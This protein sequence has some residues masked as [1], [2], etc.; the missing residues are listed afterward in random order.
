[1][2]SNCSKEF[3]IVYGSK[4]KR[5]ALLLSNLLS[6]AKINATYSDEVKYNAQE[7]SFSNQNKVVFV[8]DSKIAKDHA[9]G[10]IWRFN[11]FGIKYGW[12]GNSALICVEHTHMSRT[13]FQEFCNFVDEVKVKIDKAIE[14]A[15]QHLAP[16]IAGSENSSSAVLSGIIAGATA[17]G[18]VAASA[19]GATAIVSILGIGGLHMLTLPISGPILLSTIAGGVIG[20]AI[21]NKFGKDSKYYQ[22]FIEGAEKLTK[23]ITD[24]FVKIGDSATKVFPEN[25]KTME[26]KWEIAIRVFFCDGLKQFAEE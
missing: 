19:T 8:G 15:K 22:D 18:A 21:A 16:S 6:E 13:E 2:L 4:D 12:L 3:H 20:G 7:L 5:W 24:T 26:A 25:K 23:P 17:T 14:L 1:M 10:V 11:R 9:G